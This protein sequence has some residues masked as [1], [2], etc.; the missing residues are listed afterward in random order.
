M[1]IELLMFKNID[2]LFKYIDDEINRVRSL[3]SEYFRRLDELRIK[4]ERIK[5][6][7]KSISSIAGGAIKSSEGKEIDLMGIKVVIDP[8]YEQE[9]NFI[10]EAAKSLQDRLTV[11]QKIRK[12][13]EPLSTIEDADIEVL[14]MNGVPVRIHIRIR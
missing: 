7:E 11:L 10:E 4:V 13:I 3:L 12:A 5:K 1:S 6:L 8:S 2:E 14:I 9:V